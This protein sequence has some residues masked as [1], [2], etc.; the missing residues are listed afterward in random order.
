M[1]AGRKRSRGCGLLFLTAYSPDFIPIKQAF[2]KIK[3]L[4]RGL[5]VPM[6]EALLEAVAMAV[7]AITP[8]D[9]LAWFAQARYSLPAFH[10]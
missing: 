10:P 3:A 2:S 8:D 7:C 5:V 6:R 1:P 4:R 9:A